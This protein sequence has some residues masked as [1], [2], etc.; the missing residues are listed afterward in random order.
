MYKDVLH[1]M[2]HATHLAEVGLLIFLAVFVAVTVRAMRTS[3]REIGSWARLP[4]ED[5]APGQAEQAKES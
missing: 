2:E 4:L 3:R 1:R 5:P